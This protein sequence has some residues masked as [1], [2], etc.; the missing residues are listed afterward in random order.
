MLEFALN[1][2]S[3]KK[4][5]EKETDADAGGVVEEGVPAEF[6]CHEEHGHARHGEAD[7]PVVDMFP[8]ETERVA[9]L[10]LDTDTGI[11]ERTHLENR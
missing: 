4:N 10:S 7:H 9:V 3:E 8:L 1:K 6:G 5:G 2:E 11:L